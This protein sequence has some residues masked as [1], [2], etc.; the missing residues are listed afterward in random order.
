M[1]YHNFSSSIY[2]F[3]VTVVLVSIVILMALFSIQQFGTSKVGFIFAPALAL[4]FF[5]LGAIGLYN[6]LKS[7]VMVVKAFNPTYIFFFFKKNNKDACSSLE[8]CVLFITSMVCFY[9]ADPDS[10][11]S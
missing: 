8:D 1:N 4:W 9:L 7:D 3:T 2:F 6:L 11:D 5:S 10:T